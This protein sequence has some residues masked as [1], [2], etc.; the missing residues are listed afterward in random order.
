MGGVYGSD[1]AAA[2]RAVR[3]LCDTLD[4]AS[5]PLPEAPR[6]WQDIDAMERQLAGKKLQLAAFVE[7][8]GLWAREGFPSA[9]HY[10]AARAGTSVGRARR[11][12]K[13]SAQ[14]QNLPAVEAAV[15]TGQLSVDQA[16]EVADAAT[17]D[18]SAEQNLLHTASRKPLHELREECG[19]VKAAA[20]PDDTARDRAI[21]TQRS[22][23]DFDD[24]EGGWNLKVRNTKGAGAEFMAGLE[25]FIQARF[26]AARLR[27]EHE[28]REAY[29]A[30][31]LLDLLHAAQGGTGVPTGAR[32]VESKIIATIDL[33]AL[34]RGNVEDGETCEIAGVGPVSVSRLRRLLPEAFL[35]LVITN[36]VDIAHVTH[37]GRQ[38]TT[39]QRTALEARGYVCGI[40]DC[41]VTWGLEI[42]HLGEGWAP[43][44]HTR[45]DELD[46]KCGHCHDRKTYQ[47]WQDQGPPGKRRW[48]HTPGANQP[49]PTGDPPPEPDTLFGDNPAA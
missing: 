12:L 30:D 9:A 46:W 48:T 24:S 7:D 15:E 5:V 27:G 3:A 37:F 39:A 13:T 25:P 8:S 10:L 16:A 35:A 32:R 36:G 45:L 1:V 4:P 17:A 42:D 19:R 22:L 44:R 11:D 23:R 2:A 40:E 20:Q 41:G 26:D 47:G 33:A 6:L 49:P 43:T 14:I 38:V 31:A 21:H 29:A 28:P 34:A 18:R